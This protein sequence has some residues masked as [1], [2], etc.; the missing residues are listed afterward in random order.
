MLVEIPSQLAPKWRRQALALLLTFILAT[1]LRCKLERH[2]LLLKLGALG[3]VLILGLWTALHLVNF[4]S[5]QR[6]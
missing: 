2:A 5:S 1:F 4:A 6:T 3:H